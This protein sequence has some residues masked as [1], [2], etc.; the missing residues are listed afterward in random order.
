VLRVSPE[1]RGP[2]DAFD[3]T[4]R[5]YMARRVD[6]ASAAEDLV[7]DV[8]ER[9]HRGQVA[10]GDV[11]RV[12]AWVFRV[13]RSVLVDHYRRTGRRRQR[14][15]PAASGEPEGAHSPEASPD[16]GGPADVRAQVAA[17]LPGFIAELD[18]IYREALELTDIRG[19]PQAQAARE[20]DIGLS[21]LKSRVQR[22][23]RLVQRKVLACCH[24]ELDARGRVLDYAPRDCGCCE[25]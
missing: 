10:L 12:D 5:R 25:G 15:V 13:A 11:E 16:A 4:L 22:G 7:Q 6:D 19:L 9:L 20:L 18:P 21:A 14:E 17:W 24:I 3:G 1:A 23:R 8:Y 2:A